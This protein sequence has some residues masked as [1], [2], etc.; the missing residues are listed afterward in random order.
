MLRDYVILWFVSYLPCIGVPKLVGHEFRLANTAWRTYWARW[1]RYRTIHA[2]QEY[3][4]ELNT[5]K[6]SKC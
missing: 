6:V 5:K 1:G 2:C 4:K 3:L